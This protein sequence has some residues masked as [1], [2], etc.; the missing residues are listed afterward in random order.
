MLVGVTQ[1]DRQDVNG[2]KAEE[3]KINVV[4]Q[5][6]EETNGEIDKNYI[7]FSVQ[8]VI[9]MM[10]P[11]IS[12]K[13]AAGWCQRCNNRRQTYLDTRCKVAIVKG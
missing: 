2:K 1:V 10:K 8:Y 12:L 6:V 9:P 4:E 11:N 7:L 13:R 5:R 3:E